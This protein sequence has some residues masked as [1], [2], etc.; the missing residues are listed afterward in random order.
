MN[1][2]RILAA[3]KALPLIRFALMLGGGVVASISAGQVQYW[4]AFG[5]NFPNSE[6]VWLARIQAVAWMGLGSLAIVAVV[7]ITLAWGKV[8]KINATLPNGANVNL[9]FDEGQEQPSTTTTV[10]TE[11]KS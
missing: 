2:Q 8:G 9:D 11:V 1:G 3:L 4:L 5:R 10:T 7:M 6:A